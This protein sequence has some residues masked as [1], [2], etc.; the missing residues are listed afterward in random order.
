MSKPCSVRTWCCHHAV[1]SVLSHH[2][3]HLHDSSPNVSASRHDPDGQPAAPVA[4]K[5][6]D[7]KDSSTRH[8]SKEAGGKEHGQLHAHNA[9]T[10]PNQPIL[11]RCT[12]YPQVPGH[13]M[14]KTKATYKMQEVQASQTHQDTSWESYCTGT[15]ARVM[16]VRGTSNTQHRQVQ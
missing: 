2:H 1:L 4:E 7:A 10:Q 16:Q 5:W 3:A 14:Q 11:G 6:H 15:L 12:P 13:L 8:L 9:V